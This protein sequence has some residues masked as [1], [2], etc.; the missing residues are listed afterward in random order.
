L[1]LNSRASTWGIH[2]YWVGAS[3]R[4]QS[5]ISAS[6]S[7]RADCSEKQVELIVSLVK[8]SGR[9]WIAPDGDKAG[10]RHAQALLALISP[11]RFVRLIKMADGKQPT[12]LSP[13]E[14]KTRFTP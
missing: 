4:R 11:H 2:I 1:I 6:A 3:P 5:S 13:E 14:L 7:A 10:E 12:D 9:V 8:L